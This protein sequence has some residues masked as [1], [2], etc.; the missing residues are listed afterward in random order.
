MDGLKAGVWRKANPPNPFGWA[1]PCLRSREPKQSAKREEVSFEVV[2]LHLRVPLVS[3]ASGIFRSGH[4]TSQG[5][6]GFNRIRYLSKWSSYIS[7]LRWFQPHQVSF[8]V[9]IL[10]LLWILFRFPLT[11]FLSSCTF[12]SLGRPF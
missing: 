5:S 1:G 9:A 12:Y 3:T 10:H 7:G 2:I 11:H 6:V 4:P 8:E